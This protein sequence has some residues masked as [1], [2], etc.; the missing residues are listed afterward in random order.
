MKNCFLCVK[1]YLDITQFFLLGLS[2]L[3][4]E[5][6]EVILQTI[7]VTTHQTSDSY[8]LFQCWIYST[9]VWLRILDVCLCSMNIGMKATGSYCIFIRILPL[10]Q[11]VNSSQQLRVM[12]APIF[13]SWPCSLT[14]C[15]PLTSPCLSS[16]WM[17]LSSPELS[18]VNGVSTS[19]SPELRLICQMVQLPFYFFCQR[20]TEGDD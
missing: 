14:S 5:S 11:S 10:R 6:T 8:G 3:T 7:S 4:V 15:S 12:S 18:S 20:G 1:A 2:H 9:Y 19:L 16:P 17:F 13:I